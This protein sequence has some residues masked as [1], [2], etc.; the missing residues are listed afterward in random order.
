MAQAP[1][2]APAKP[3]NSPSKDPQDVKLHVGD[4]VKHGEPPPPV[5]TVGDE[6][7]KRSEEIEKVGVEKWKEAHDERDPADR[8][9]TVMGVRQPTAEEL[10]SKR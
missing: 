3:A 10:R 4:D 1:Q 6:Q 7:R 5:E 8:G 2:P 9:K